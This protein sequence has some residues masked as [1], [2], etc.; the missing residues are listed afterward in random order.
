MGGSGE[1]ASRKQ[2][3]SEARERY[4]RMNAGANP[5]HPCAKYTITPSP[6]ST[7]SAP[8]TE[9]EERIAR[10]VNN[11]L[12]DGWILENGCPGT[13]TPHKYV[14]H[15]RDLLTSR[16]KRL[17]D[18][19]LE[20]QTVKDLMQY[21][22]RSTVILDHQVDYHDAMATVKGL[23][24]ALR[25]RDLA[26]GRKLDDIHMSVQRA[27]KRS[28][29]HGDFEFLDGVAKIE[30]IRRRSTPKSG[31]VDLPYSS[32]GESRIT[33]RTFV[34]IIKSL[35]RTSALYNGD[36]QLKIYRRHIEIRPAHWL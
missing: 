22:N 25:E 21:F 17:V 15:I 36:W 8:E 2:R 11:N 31:S 3:T 1:A 19:M 30:A 4:S 7:E 26:L 20:R 27:L 12:P 24:L 34:S 16:L 9:F 35:A 5:T 23:R 6:T 29:I 10:Y 18:A 32:R 28:L 13:W 14:E 33:R